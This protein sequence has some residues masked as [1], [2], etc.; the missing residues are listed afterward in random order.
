LRLIVLTIAFILHSCSPR[1]SVH[2]HIT[3]HIKCFSINN[4]DDITGTYSH[5]DGFT[6]YQFILEN[7]F[8]FTNT[9]YSDAIDINNP[10]IGY[11]GK[12]E[13]LDTLIYFFYDD[14]I[15]TDTTSDEIKERYRNKASERLQLCHY[16]SL[17]SE[18]KILIIRDK[19]CIIPRWEYQ[20]V[21]EYYTNADLDKTADIED[22]LLILKKIE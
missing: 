10:I 6:R 1:L 12:Y 14:I 21:I 8:T 20:K 19:L 2:D 4:A 5:S 13:I 22:R 16:T 15:F 9:I 18:S 17:F 7:D 3:D 11:S